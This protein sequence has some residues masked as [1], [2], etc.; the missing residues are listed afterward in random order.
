MSSTVVAF[1][2]PVGVGKTTLGRAVSAQLKIGFIDGD[3]YSAPGLW[4]RSILQTSRRIVT[5]CEEQLESCPAVIM[6]Y[7]LRCTNWLFYKET[8]RRCGIAFH[9]ISLTADLAHISNRERILASDE[10]A[11]TSQMLAQGYGRRSFSNL[12]VRT[13]EVSFELT[14]DRLAEEVGNLISRP[15][16]V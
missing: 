8:F 11:R 16:I 3:D 15:P 6:A 12:V 14:R 10:V 7:P 4:L 2:G 1:E 13:D 9:C 5:A